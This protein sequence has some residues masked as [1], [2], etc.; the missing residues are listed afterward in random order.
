MTI[1]FFTRRSWEAAVRRKFL[2]ISVLK[3][4]AL[5]TGKQLCCS[6]F[7]I[8][9]F[10]PDLTF[11]SMQ[12]YAFPRSEMSG[13]SDGVR[14]PVALGLVRAYCANW[15]RWYSG[16]SRTF[17]LQ[18]RLIPYGT[19]IISFTFGCW[20]F[21]FHMQIKSHS[22]VAHKVLFQLHASAQGLVLVNF[23]RTFVKS[24]SR[25]DK[26]PRVYWYCFEYSQSTL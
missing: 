25:K 13:P 18:A 6:I 4:F 5:I 2:K 9:S 10:L 7:L 16:C 1:G 12:W 24:H 11:Y 19:F 15:L 20:Y 23:L 17:S 22:Q 14:V 8:K 3:N 21:F 26:L